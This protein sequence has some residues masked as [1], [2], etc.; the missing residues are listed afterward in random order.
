MRFAKHLHQ[1]TGPENLCIAGGVTLNSA[2]RGEVLSDVPFKN[3]WSPE[4]K[5]LLSSAD[6]MSHIR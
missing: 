6:H 5:P 2:A 3:P 4:P 1:E